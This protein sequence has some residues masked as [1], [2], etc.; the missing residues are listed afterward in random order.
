MIWRG[1]ISPSRS[2][3]DYVREA[4]GAYFAK[5][6]HRRSTTRLQREFNRELVQVLV[7]HRIIT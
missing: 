1:A 7:R 6:S 5:R 3:A 4:I 2:L